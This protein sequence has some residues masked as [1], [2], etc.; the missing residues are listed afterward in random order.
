[1]QQ[2]K[3]ESPALPHSP[4]TLTKHKPAIV[5]EILKPPNTHS[6]SACSAMIPL[7]VAVT[8]AAA[9]SFAVANA[10]APGACSVNA[11][12]Q[13]FHL[14]GYRTAAV[15]EDGL[16]DTGIADIFDE[17]VRPAALHS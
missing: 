4:H 17:S 10:E 7:L 5:P 9:A 14:E 13:Y 8:A 12:L 3:T 16:L 6:S 11:G 1:M 2:F 15:I